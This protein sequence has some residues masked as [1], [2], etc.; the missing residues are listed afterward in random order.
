MITTSLHTC[1]K[2]SRSFSERKKKKKKKKK[3]TGSGTIDSSDTT[4]KIIPREKMIP[5]I[6]FRTLRT[7]NDTGFSEF[8][9]TIFEYQ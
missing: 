3:R 6:D 4:K 2:I 1:I 9:I 5:G 7:K 8:R